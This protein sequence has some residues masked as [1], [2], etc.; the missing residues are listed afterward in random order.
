MNNGEGSKYTETKNLRSAEIAKLIR[1]DIKAAIALGELPAGI[2]CSVTTDTFSGGSS[3]DIRVKACPVQIWTEAFLTA[4]PKVFFEGER[5]TEEAK[6]ILKT[7]KAIHRQ[8]NFDHSD[9]Q[10]DYFHVRY[11][12]DAS[13]WWELEKADREATIARKVAETRAAAEAAAQDLAAADERVTVAHVQ[14]ADA[15]RRA[16]ELDAKIE[17]TRIERDAVLAEMAAL[18]GIHVGAA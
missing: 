7:L 11:Y 8:Y 1:A 12:G 10:T 16:A 15:E 3:I 13:F 6:A 14:L 5:V 2:K 9:I 18:Q 17:A 4:D